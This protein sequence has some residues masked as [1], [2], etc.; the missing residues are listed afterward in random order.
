MSSACSFIF[1]QIKV[2]FIR[3][4]SHLDSFWNRGT[5]EL[6]NGLSCSVVPNSTPLCLVNGLPPT[7]WDFLTSVCLWYETYLPIS[8]LSWL[9]HFLYS[10]IL[11]FW[12]CIRKHLTSDFIDFSSFKEPG[13]DPANIHGMKKNLPRL[14]QQK[15]KKNPGPRDRPLPTAKH[16]P[17]KTW[18]P[19][20]TLKVFGKPSTSAFLRKYQAS[21]FMLHLQNSRQVRRKRRWVMLTSQSRKPESKF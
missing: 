1:M 20:C 4:V 19:G 11:D 13:K 17:G 18:V 8:W 16:A 14:F 2:L 12:C 5:R 10:V 21:P 7:S 3:M 15:L 9:Q 6:G